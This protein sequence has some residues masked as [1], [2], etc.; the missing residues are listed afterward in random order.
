MPHVTVNGCRIWYDLR[1]SGDYLLQIGGAGF[2]HENFALVTEEM[3]KHFTVIEMDQRG[4]GYSD[5][6]VQTYTM[7]IWA[8]DTAALLDAIGVERTLVHGSSTGGMIAIKLAAK[9][10]EKV[11][12]LVLDATAAKLDF[13]G[14]SQFL[15]RKA[16]AQA[17][18]M[19]SEALAH[20]LATLALSRNYLDSPA[21]VGALVEMVQGM[22]ERSNSVETWCCLCDAM[23]EVDLRDDL[24]KI[25]APTLVMCG[26]L[27]N[28]TP[29][30]AG[31][32]GAGM[33][34][35]AEH[36]PHAELYVIEGCGHTNLVEMPELSTEVVV[37]F[38]KRGAAKG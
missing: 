12:A 24:P 3:A 27:D 5:R 8:D 33:R 23:I 11:E 17:F 18:G 29:L 16:L 31:P 7:D 2:A 15:V 6:P 30:D 36:I 1:G 10:P 34:Y 20:D 35:M 14:R 4:N 21:G 19:G 25:E 28:N 22:L 13:M 37:D 26:E 32:Q 9:Y 38:F